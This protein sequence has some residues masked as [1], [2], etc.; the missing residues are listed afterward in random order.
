M[1]QIKINKKDYLISVN[2]RVVKTL[3][4]VK[5]T[6]VLADDKMAWLDDPDIIEFVTWQALKEG[7]EY[8]GEKLDISKKDLRLHMDRVT[9]LE[10]QNDLIEELAKAWNYSLE[11]TKSLVGNSEEEK[12]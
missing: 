5:K 7:E 10:V 9:S 6:D 2:N 11:K 3:F 8:T 12:K 1:R 4:N